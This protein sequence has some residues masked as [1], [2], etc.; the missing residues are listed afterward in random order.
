MGDELVIQDLLR[1]C[2][3]FVLAARFAFQEEQNG[4]KVF[5]SMRGSAEAVYPENSR[6]AG[7]E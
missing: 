5:S 7:A 6:S 4:D 3:R 1:I 2:S